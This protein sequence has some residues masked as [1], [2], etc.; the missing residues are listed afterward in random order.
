MTHETRPCTGCGQPL[1]WAYTP[2][3]KPMPLDPD[4]VPPAR[5]TYVVDGKHC[6][7]SEPLTDPP[8]TQHHMNHWA[9]CPRADDFK[10]KGRKA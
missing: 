3:G 9:T 4:P 10:T 1:I 6:R 8:E 7:P 2:N 5:G